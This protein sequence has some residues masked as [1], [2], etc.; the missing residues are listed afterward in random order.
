M[1][2]QNNFIEKK[3]AHIVAITLKGFFKKSQKSIMFTGQYM[4]S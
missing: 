3:A 1:E 4:S 2:E